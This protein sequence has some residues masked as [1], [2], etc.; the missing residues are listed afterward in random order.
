[1]KKILLFFAALFISSLLHAQAT[2][3]VGKVYEINGVKGLVYKVSANGRHGMMMSLK[4]CPKKMSA[5]VSDKSMFADARELCKDDENGVNAMNAIEKYIEE[6]GTDWSKFP[7]F[8]W[9]R[10]LGEGW[11]IPSKKELMEMV[12]CL[13]EGAEFAK[14]NIMTGKDKMIKEVKKEL[15][16]HKGDPYVYPM[17]SSTGTS[18]TNKKGKVSYWRYG[19]VL[20]QNQNSGGFIG[21]IINIAVEAT[22]DKVQ[23]TN[24][25]YY[26]SKVAGT[27]AI[28]AF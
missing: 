11:Y 12:S 10:S 28:R 4:Y 21:S 6:H 23:L 9:A 24:L 27:R 2:Y 19:L 1:M 13:Y 15:K 16:N 26:N 18:T 17:L 7:C 22:V 14:N 3:E 20:M 8:N 5:L 25:I